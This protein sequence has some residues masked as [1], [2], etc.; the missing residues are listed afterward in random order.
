MNDLQLGMSLAVSREALDF[1]AGMVAGI[2]QGS[3]SACVEQQ[4]G[5][6]R[7]QSL[8]LEGI[9]EKINITV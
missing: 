2:I 4:E 1:Q 6:P 3:I 7:A 8:A 5:M 9:G